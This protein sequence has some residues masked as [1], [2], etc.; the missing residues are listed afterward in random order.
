MKSRINEVRN[1]QKIAGLL[2]EDNDFNL[3]DNPF[4]T[5]LSEPVVYTFGYDLS[6]ILQV[7]DYVKDNYVVDI[8]SDKDKEFSTKVDALAFI[9]PGDDVMK[10]LEVYSQEILDDEEFQ[11]LISNTNGEGNYIEDAENEYLEED[12]D[13]NLDFNPLSK[14]RLQSQSLSKDDIM[15]VQGRVYR[16]NRPDGVSV[17]VLFDDYEIEEMVDAYTGIG[18][19]KGEDD[20]GN[21]YEMNADFSD[22]GG[23]S[24]D[25]EPHFDTLEFHV[26][27]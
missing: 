3:S 2:K 20:D 26:Q 25:I 1:L 14:G 16:I 18:W 17:D 23:Y 7:Q 4:K 10:Y 27:D 21:T 24:V 13:F 19:M 5:R 12:D 6:R 15:H 11:E 8:I 22:T 9:G